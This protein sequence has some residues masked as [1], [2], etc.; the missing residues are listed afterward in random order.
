MLLSHVHLGT[1]DFPRAMQF[2]T[3]LM[4]QL[5]LVQKLRDDAKRWAGWM[6]PEAPRPLFLVGHPFDG[7]PAHP[8][9]GHLTALLAPDRP[10]VDR[11][12][13]WAIHNGAQDE[14]PPG[15]RPHYHPDYYGAYFRDPDGNK[16]A[17]CCHTPPTS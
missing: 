13:A 7:A 15:P 16:L 9:N 10:T 8:G 11:V 6:H 12:Y 1:N 3:G 17:L 5:G 2:Y 4:Q 14:G